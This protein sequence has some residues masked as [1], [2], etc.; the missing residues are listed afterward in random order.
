MVATISAIGSSA[1]ASS[2]YEADDYYAD[3][4]LSPSEWQGEGAKELGL[5]GEV[6]RD[7]AAFARQGGRAGLAEPARGRTHDGLAALDRLVFKDVRGVPV[8]QIR[9]LVPQAIVRVLRVGALEIFHCQPIRFFQDNRNGS[10]E[11]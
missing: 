7:V 2:Y 9:H 6:E 1:Q 11:A 10:L 8:E 5:A 4:G 3:G